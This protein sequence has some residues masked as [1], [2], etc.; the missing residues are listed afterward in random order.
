MSRIVRKILQVRKLNIILFFAVGHHTHSY[1]GAA[2][3]LALCL[4]TAGALLGTDT[5]CEASSSSDN[6][7]LQYRAV[8]SQAS[9]F[10]QNISWDL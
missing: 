7:A 4:S 6:S 3:M 1:C 2:T 9:A 8:V 10:V 5:C